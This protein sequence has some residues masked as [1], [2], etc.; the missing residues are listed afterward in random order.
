MIKIIDLV[1]QDNLRNADMIAEWLHRANKD[2]STMTGRSGCAPELTM[3]EGKTF[4]LFRYRTFAISEE[5][6]QG[7]QS[8]DLETFGEALAYGVGSTEIVEHEE[9]IKVTKCQYDQ[10]LNEYDE[11][12]MNLYAEEEYNLKLSNAMKKPNLTDFTIQ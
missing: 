8:E 5:F 10:M 2:W 9:W 11:S 12:G 3:F 4:I 7:L 6:L 1:L